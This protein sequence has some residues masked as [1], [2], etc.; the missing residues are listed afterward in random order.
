MSIKKQQRQSR[1]VSKESSQRNGVE[2]I[3]KIE[4]KKLLSEFKEVLSTL[5]GYRNSHERY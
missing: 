1:N 2:S 3:E 5:Q 4:N